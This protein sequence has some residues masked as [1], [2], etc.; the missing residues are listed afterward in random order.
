MADDSYPESKEELMSAIDR[1]WKA[2]L[3]VI[4]LLSPAQM[5]RPDSGG[6]S[7]KDNLS[8]LSTWMTF[9][10]RAYLGGEPSYLAMG[11]DAE[12]YKTLDEDGINAVIFERN[13]N[14]TTDDVI[15]ELK[16]S[17]NETVK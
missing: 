6:W 13:R 8:H 9:M 7:P 14:R 17:Y 5:T 12:K 4:S 2:L 15:A 11:M 1:E 10:R 16:K 3:Q